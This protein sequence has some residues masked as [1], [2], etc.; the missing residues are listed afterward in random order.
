MPVRDFF[1]YDLPTG[2]KATQQLYSTGT[3][4]KDNLHLLYYF[5]FPLLTCAR[6]LN[7]SL[8]RGEH[9][10]AGFFF[11]SHHVYKH[12]T[13]LVVSVYLSCKGP[14]LWTWDRMG[15]WTLDIHP[16]I[17]A[18]TFDQLDQAEEDMPESCQA[19]RINHCGGT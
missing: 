14:I 16:I 3:L 7:T 2:C 1:R 17:L 9:S 4:L 18:L 19:I 5:V 15:H 12:T 6:S 11:F 8:E 13:H 10:T